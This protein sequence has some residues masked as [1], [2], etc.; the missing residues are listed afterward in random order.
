M[1]TGDLI[2]RT[3]G[4][5][6]VRNIF[7]GVNRSR[8]ALTE[9]RFHFSWQPFSPRFYR[10]AWEHVRQGVDL[11]RH[12]HSTSV[13]VPSSRFLPQCQGLKGWN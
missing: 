3:C 1:A 11:V 7:F 5:A 12:S 8:T 2:S 9:S 10:I 13:L 4:A 6:D